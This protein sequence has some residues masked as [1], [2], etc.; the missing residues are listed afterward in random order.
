ML[1][2]YII[3][4]TG[5]LYEWYGAVLTA[6]RSI[7]AIQGYHEYKDIWENP[8]IGEE[9]KCLCEFGN[10]HDPLAVAMLKQI[11]G[12]NTI[13]GHVSRKIAT[14]CNAFIRHGDIIECTVTGNRR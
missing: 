7:S 13:V 11:D 6:H 8:I 4:S 14:S 9:L 10:R 3:L 5:F 12:H 1:M 2:I